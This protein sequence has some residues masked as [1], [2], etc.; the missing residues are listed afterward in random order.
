MDLAPSGR[1][2]LPSVSGAQVSYWLDKAGKVAWIIGVALA[3][4]IIASRPH[5]ATAAQSAATGLFL[6]GGTITLP[7]YK[8]GVVQWLL[9]EKTEAFFT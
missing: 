9:V 6:V 8:P 1:T 2:S 4:G 5:A 7:G 3:R